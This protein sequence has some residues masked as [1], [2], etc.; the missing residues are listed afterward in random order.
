M[1]SEDKRGVQKKPIRVW[2]DG[3]FD[4]FHFGHANAFRQARSLG[5]KLIVGV[6]NDREITEHKG[7]PV[8]NE[9]ERYRLVRAVK[10][11]DEVIEGAPYV[12]YLDTLD[13]Y[14]CDFAAHGDDIVTTATGVNTY[15]LVKDAGRYKE[16]RRT[17]GISTTELLSRILKRL[18]QLRDQ[19]HG[20]EDHA[21]RRSHSVDSVVSTGVDLLRSS[22]NCGTK[23]HSP[24]NSG[25]SDTD[26]SHSTTPSGPNWSTGGMSYMPNTLRITQFCLSQHSLDG[27][28]EP[29][30]D[31]IVVYA[32]GAY[33]LFHIGHLS[34]FEK[35][36]ELGTYLL[37]GLHSDRNA[38]FESRR[39]GCIMTL[40]ERL[41]S[42]LACRY[43]H[44]V[45]IDAPYKIPASLLDNFKVNYVVVGMDTKLIPTLD[46]EDPMLIPKQRNIFR[47]LDSGSTVTTASV[48]SR[49]LKN[50]LLYEKRNR[51]KEAKESK[52]IYAS[53][54]DSPSCVELAVN[55]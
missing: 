32:P 30:P 38:N 12:T 4:L 36:M 22:K 16:F 9:Q 39:M 45:I 7:P 24:T 54:K 40:Q 19:R 5:D 6:H 20:D 55:Q 33:D 11:V 3:C 41:L 25:D 21:L 35:C 48:I 43:V 29:T 23:R 28:R 26:H 8:F 31:D 18:K 15:Q 37:I 50:R 1:E 42:V 46:G 10:W 17:E 13:K 34:F 51:S 47:R 27:F 53:L 2:V 14:D 44:N 52:E 49:I